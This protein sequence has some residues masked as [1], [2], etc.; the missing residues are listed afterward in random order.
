MAEQRSG[1]SVSTSKRTRAW[2]FKLKRNSGYLT[3]TFQASLSE[4]DDLPNIARDGWHSS[5][6][7]DCSV[8]FLRVERVL[9][10]GHRVVT[11][12][13]EESELTVWLKFNERKINLN[14]FQGCGY[15]V[16]TFTVSRTFG[17]C[18]EST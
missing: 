18:C 3:V 9:Y 5:V 8:S 2:I 11:E 1:C 6:N 16:Y 15:Y 14:D 7:S 10:D 12:V 13:N 4:W 17:Q